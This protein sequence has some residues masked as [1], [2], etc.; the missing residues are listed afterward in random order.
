R[1]FMRL[2][3]LD[4]D[5]ERGFL[6]STTHGAETHALAAG[7]A[8]MA[9]Y[10]DEDVTGFL[11]QQGKRLRVRVEGLIQELDLGGYFEC[12][13]RDCCLFYGTRDANKLPSQA[14]R[15]VFLQETIR[16]GVIAPAWV[17]SYSHTDADIDRTI[18]IVGEALDIYRKALGE[19]IDKYLEGR[20][21]KPVFR[22]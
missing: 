5:R 8:T 12:Y 14:F 22:P 7:I 13:G 20:A 2:G 6:L 11:H 1:E 4:H 9:V 15:T 3:G 10:R 16:R 17:V 21:V 19:G 18:E